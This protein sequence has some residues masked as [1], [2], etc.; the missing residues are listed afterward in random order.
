MPLLLELFSGT[1]SMG[2]AFR[3]LGWEVLSLDCDPTTGADVIGDIMEWEPPEGFRPD[4]VHASP[5]C[6]EFSRALTTRPRDL[7]KGLRPAERALEL[8][9]RLQPTSY[10]IENPGTGLLPQQAAFR[11]LPFKLVTYC[12]FGFPYK[13]LT[14]VATD[15]GELW[16]PPP[17]CS[18]RDPCK[19]KVGTRHPLTAQRGTKRG[20]DGVCRGGA[21]SQTD[22]YAM[23]P[24]LCDE[25]A[26]AAALTLR[27]SSILESEE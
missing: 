18:A 5:P 2:R 20:K 25:I 16:D 11:E 7:V 17:P 22:L 9:R 8:I 13:K 27:V 26:A 23:P 14:W 15:L 1:G 6:T 3:E 4:H 19:A 21:F 12:R 24:Q 10:S